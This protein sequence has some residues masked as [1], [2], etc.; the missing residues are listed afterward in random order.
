MILNCMPPYRWDISNP[1]LGYLKGFLE[2]KGINVQNVY[3]NLILFQEIMKYGRIMKDL[4]MLSKLPPFYVFTVLIC[5]HLLIKDN[6]NFNKTPL[7]V[8][9]SSFFPKGKIEELVTSIEDKIDQYIGDNNLHKATLAGFT[10]KTRQW[11]MSYYLIHRLKEMN[12][13]IKILV[14][15]IRS[16]SQG[17]SFMN[18]FPL[19]DFAI[20]GEGEFP[21]L[22]LTRALEENTDIRDVPQLI[23]RKDT[24]AHSTQK[25][26]EFLDLD[27]YPFADHSDYFSTLRTYLPR[28]MRILIPIWGSRSCP[29]NKCKFCVLNEEY[30]YHARS[31]ENVIEEIRFQSN[32]HHIDSFIFVDNEFPG[33]KKR[34]RILLKALSKLSASRRE[35]Y[36][37]FGEISPIFLDSETGRY[38]R[39][40]SFTSLQIGFEALTDSLL[41]KMEKRHRFAHNIQALK[42]GSQYN[43]RIDYLNILQGIPTETEEDI[44]ESCVNLRFL[45]FL[46]RTHA[47]NLIPFVLYKGSVFY[48]EM[49]EEERKDWNFDQFWAEIHPTGL[50][51][52]SDRFEF[53]GFHRERPHHALWDD[54]EM[55]M[56]SYVQ[57]NC[58]YIWI[59]YEDGSFIEEK[60]SSTCT[61]VLDRDETDLLVF[62]DSI[63]T[64]RQVK[65][66]FKHK[67]EEDLLET[68][69][70]LREAGLV[71]Y[72]KDM[73]TIISIVEAWRRELAPQDQRI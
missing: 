57:E 63:K 58:S 72:D 6:W 66:K 34:F 50:V 71:Y 17:Y 69:N 59:E 35:P 1:A 28:E 65:Q 48:D 53:S 15:G 22:Y 5:K 8:F 12:P 52:V 70:T 3:W 55:M 51:P 33:N 41:R 30:S 16:E 31:P 62:C 27:L 11:M 68:L 29:W 46:L 73:H 61:Y 32:R 38:I 47:L 21:L 64:L 43:L 23:Y 25:N 45:R 10:L 13:E 26:S 36:H 56:K 54:F 2:A 60:G 44:L 9:F 14:G 37:F 39:F 67:K 4:P 49:S 7:D 24:T 19:A 40:A 20:W 42:L 18:L